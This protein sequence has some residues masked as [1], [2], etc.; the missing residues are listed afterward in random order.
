MCSAEYY[1]YRYPGTFGERTELTEVSATGIKFVPNHKGVFG[2]VL[3]PYRTLPKTSVGYLHGKNTPG[4]L[5]SAP[6]RTHP[7][8]FF[9]F[10]FTITFQLL[11]KL[12][13][14]VSSLLPPGTCLQFLS[15]VRRVQH[16]HCSPIFIECC[17][18]TLS[19]FPRV[20]L[21]TRTRPYEL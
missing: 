8:S 14:Q 17:S 18:L 4:I 3:R 16:S 11:D 7:S 1:R 12:W 5:W 9:C 2:R 21:C 19:C 15:R 20:N 13:S 6:Y 10:V